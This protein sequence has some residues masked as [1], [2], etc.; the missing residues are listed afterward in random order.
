M[1]LNKKH[2]MAIGFVIIVIA[3]ILISQFPLNEPELPENYKENFLDYIPDFE[4]DPSWYE[5]DPIETSIPLEFSVETTGCL[6]EVKNNE[7]I[8]DERNPSEE[9]INTP[10]VIPGKKSLTVEYYGIM[11]CEASEITFETFIDTDGFII[12]AEGENIDSD[13]FIFGPTT[14]PPEER[15]NCMCNYK[16]VITATGMESKAYPVIFENKDADDWLFES[17]EIQ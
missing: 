14:S 9:Q 6:G 16:A 13:K 4:P 8:P 15:W 17:V 2:Y 7:F 11:F 10:F 12:I 3:F 1:Q 5:A